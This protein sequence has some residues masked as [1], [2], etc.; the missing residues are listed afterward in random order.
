M[1]KIKGHEVANFPREM[2]IG[3]FE[4]TTNL[5]MMTV[6]KMGDETTKTDFESDI[7]KWLYVFEKLGVPTEILDNLTKDELVEAVKNFNTKDE[8]T[9]EVID[10]IEVKGKIYKAS[11]KE[12]VEIGARQ[13]GLIE[14]LVKKYPKQIPSMVVAVVFEDQELTKNEHLSEAHAKHKAEIFRKEVSAGVA[15]PYIPWLM[16]EIFKGKKELL[17]KE[18]NEKNG[19]TPAM[20]VVKS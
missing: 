12:G 20:E 19:N 7:E 5:T 13:F 10:E 3:D 1:I 16:N 15:V 18:L 17:E 6:S 9:Y 4:K 14:K 11:I 8:Q 2:T